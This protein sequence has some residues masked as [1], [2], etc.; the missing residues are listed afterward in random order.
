MCN[1]WSVNSCS[2]H[3]NG[4]AINRV[5]GPA[6]KFEAQSK[7]QAHKSDVIFIIN[8]NILSNEAHTNEA[9]RL[10][11]LHDALSNGGVLVLSFGAVM[12]ERNTNI[13]EQIQKVGFKSIHIYEEVSQCVLIQ[14]FF[15]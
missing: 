12:H 4:I 14:A 13:I 10:C 6:K 8:P 2:Y 15:H 9:L 7:Q 11:T 3:H 1:D 5:I